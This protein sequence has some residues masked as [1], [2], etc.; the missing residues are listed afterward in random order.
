MVAISQSRP[1]SSKWRHWNRNS[2]DGTKGDAAFPP[3][4][5]HFPNK[6]SSTQVFCLSEVLSL[7][8]TCSLRA[9]GHVYPPQHRSIGTRYTLPTDTPCPRLWLPHW[10]GDT[11]PVLH[12]AA[13]WEEARLRELKFFSAAHPVLRTIHTCKPNH[14]AAGV[15]KQWPGQEAHK[16]ACLLGTMTAPEL[17][18]VLPSI[19]RLHLGETAGK[20]S[21]QEPVAWILLGFNRRLWTRS[22]NL[23]VPG[24]T[25]CWITCSPCDKKVTII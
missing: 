20:I 22:L 9:Q 6:P 18:P 1:C 3:L 10:L 23:K 12:E 14:K 21:T 11:W 16:A 15:G 4:I 17:G 2:T 13:Q 19:H 5:V 24:F 8:D 7:G 25:A